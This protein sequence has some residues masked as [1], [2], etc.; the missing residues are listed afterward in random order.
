MKI[1]CTL[2]NG[3]L[4]EGREKFGGIPVRLRKRGLYCRR[5][6]SAGSCQSLYIVTNAAM[7]TEIR[8][9]NRFIDDVRR[10]NRAERLYISYEVKRSA[11]FRRIIRDNA[12]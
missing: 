3:E 11:Q 4:H 7:L 12:V 10:A 5:V 8:L 9:N 6:L 1:G 2:S